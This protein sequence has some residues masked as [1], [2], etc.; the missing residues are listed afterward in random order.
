MEY[1]EGF[2]IRSNQKQLLNKL[3]AASPERLLHLRRTKSTFHSPLTHGMVWSS[4]DQ[5]RQRV[6]SWV[7]SD[8]RDLALKQFLLLLA[9][10]LP[11]NKEKKNDVWVKSHGLLAR[12]DVKS[13]AQLTHYYSSFECF[14]PC[15]KAIK[16]YCLGNARFQGN[17][18]N[19]EH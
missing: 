11:S 19:T 5:R 10:P 13:L 6:V 12:D 16:R 15:L 17:S 2:R 8:N 7:T 14:F 18:S 3:L 9:S 4:W 1:K